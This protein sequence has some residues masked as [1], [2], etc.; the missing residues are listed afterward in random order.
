[1]RPGSHFNGRLAGPAMPFCEA[2]PA[3]LLGDVARY[4]LYISLRLAIEAGPPTLWK[5]RLALLVSR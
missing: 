3:L 4:V 1:M 2:T 5:L